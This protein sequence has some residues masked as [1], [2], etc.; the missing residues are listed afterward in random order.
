MQTVSGAETIIMSPL[1]TEDQS[2]PWAEYSLLVGDQLSSAF[3]FV[4]SSIPPSIF[5]LEKDENGTLV[6]SEEVGLGPFS[7][8][9]QTCPTPTNASIVNFDMLSNPRLKKLYHAMNDTREAVISPIMSLNPI[10]EAM[11]EQVSS[12]VF[13]PVFQEL[14]TNAN[15]NTTA[16][17]ANLALVISW[18]TYL[19]FVGHHHMNGADYVL[20]NTC[21]QS[22]TAQVDSNGAMTNFTVGDQHEDVYEHMVGIVPVMSFMKTHFNSSAG[23]QACA[24]ELYVYPTQEMRNDFKSEAAVVATSVVAVSFVVVLFIFYLLEKRFR[25][26]KKQIVRSVEKSN[27]IIASL[28]PSNVRDRL[29]GGDGGDDN[30]SRAS[31]RTSGTRRSFGFRLRNYLTEGEDAD[32]GGS[33]SNPIAD[34]FPECKWLLLYSGSSESF[35]L[36]ILKPNHLSME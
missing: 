19:A 11:F 18:E 5:K 2:D 36:C 25:D 15:S 14:K 31:R 28:F 6:S 17:V 1:V 32:D 7:P 8:V 33:Q 29:F 22:F 10:S 35:L 16:I 34:L 21:G 27:A 13:S 9:W 24:Y 20:Q 3:T 30:A 4:P 23:L 12:A 26:K